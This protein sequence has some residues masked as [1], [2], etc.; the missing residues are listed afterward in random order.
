[1]GSDV[2]VKIGD[3]FDVTVQP[4]VVASQKISLL[5]TRY[6]MSYLIRNARPAPVTVTVRQGGLGRD[7][8]VAKESQPSRRIDAYN[9]AWDVSVPAGGE[10]KVTAT[11][12]TGW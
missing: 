5:R 10:T 3:A 11:I 1:M 4:T 2:S 12:E 7:G 6:E 8:K 9:L